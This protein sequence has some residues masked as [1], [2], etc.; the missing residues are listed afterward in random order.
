MRALGLLRARLEHASVDE[1]IEYGLTDFLTDIQSDIGT[2]SARITRAFFHFAAS[3]GRHV[4]VARA[5]QI[6]AAQQ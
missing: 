6:M 1:I 3:P 2:A 5:A 4:A